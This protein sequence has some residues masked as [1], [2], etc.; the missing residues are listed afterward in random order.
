MTGHRREPRIHIA[1]LAYSQLVDGGLHIVVDTATGHAFE[2][3]EGMP[4]GIEQHL[5]RLQQIGPH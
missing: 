2:D 5:M 3:A 1:L 4:M